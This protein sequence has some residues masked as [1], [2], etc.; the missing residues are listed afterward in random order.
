MSKG[1][2]LKEVRRFIQESPDARNGDLY[3]FMIALGLEHEAI[4]GYFPLIAEAR[5]AHG[6]PRSSK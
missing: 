1:N 5:D 4:K 3:E 6:Q 2:I